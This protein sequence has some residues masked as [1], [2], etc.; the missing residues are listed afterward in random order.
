MEGYAKVAS[1]MGR[2][3]ELAI[4]RRFGQLNLQNLLYLQAELVHLE[5][6][7]KV[8]ADADMSFDTSIRNFYSKDWFTLSQSK[9]DGDDRQWQKVLQI[10]E[11]LEIYSTLPDTL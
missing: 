8:L 3:S 2:H 10:R 6:E 7:L 9:I 11:K 1:M 4:L 5:A